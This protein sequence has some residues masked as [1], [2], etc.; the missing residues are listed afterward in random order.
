MS[1]IVAHAPGLRAIASRQRR[2]YSSCA[3]NFIER[4]VGPA[5]PKRGPSA[6][7]QNL[8]SVVNL[9]N[10][11]GTTGIGERFEGFDREHRPPWRIRTMR[12]LVLVSAALATVVA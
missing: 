5:T 1:G 7:L 2:P 11:T 4:S 6:S 10:G 12:Q 3:V 8:Y 9:A